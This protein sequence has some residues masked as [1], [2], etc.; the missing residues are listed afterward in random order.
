M[1]KHII[2]NGIY[3]DLVMSTWNS[4]NGL[5]IGCFKVIRAIHGRKNDIFFVFFYTERIIEWKP[6]ICSYLKTEYEA[7][8]ENTMENLRGEIIWIPEYLWILALSI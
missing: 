5:R 1:L 7:L 2:I 6:L 8:L 3:L 4:W